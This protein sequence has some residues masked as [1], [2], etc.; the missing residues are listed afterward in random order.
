MCPTGS[1]TL[2]LHSIVFR[3]HLYFC[4][5]FTVYPAVIQVQVVQFPCSCVVLSEFLILS[6]NLI[7]LLSERL[8]V[9]IS[10]LLHLL[11]SDLLPVMW[12]ILEF[13]QSGTDKNAYSSQH[14]WWRVL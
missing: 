2:Y 7:A 12:S 6:S 3:E 14:L 13:V 10:I 5:H 8:F 11:R 9:T 4:F 1:G